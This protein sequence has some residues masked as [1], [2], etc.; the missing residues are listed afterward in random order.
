MSTSN[1]IWRLIVEQTAE[2]GQIIDGKAY[3]DKLVSL[4]KEYPNAISNRITTSVP[5]DEDAPQWEEILSNFEKEYKFC[6]REC[7]EL[8]ITKFIHR[9]HMNRKFSD[10]A[11]EVSFYQEELLVQFYPIVLD[12]MKHPHFERPYQIGGQLPSDTSVHLQFFK[13]IE[14]EDRYY[15]YLKTFGFKT[16]FTWLKGIDLSKTSRKTNSLIDKESY[17]RIYR[18]LREDYGRQLVEGWTENSNP[19]KT[20]FEDCGIAAYI[21]EIIN[22]GL[23][24]KPNKFVDIGCG[25]GLLVH[26]LNLTGLSGYGIDVRS[27][28]LWKT[29]LKHVDLRESTVEPQVI[30]DNEPHFD[31]GV[32]LLIGNHSD[33]LTPWIPVM[34]AKLNC[35]FFLIPCCP[36]DFFGKYKNNGSHLGQKRMVSQYES[37]FEWTV[38]VAERLGFDCQLDRLAIP[39]TKRLC[40]IGRIPPHGL[41]PNIAE[42][43]ELMTQGQKFVAR[44]RAIKNNNCMNIPVSE[45]DRMAKKLFDYVLKASDEVRDGWHCGGEVPL[46]ELAAILTDED[47]KMMKDQDGGLQTFLRNHHQIFHVYQATC[48]LRDFRQPQVKRDRPA[49]SKKR[50][51]D[52]EKETP[53]KKM[54][55]FMALYHPDGCAVGPEAC[56]Y[57][58]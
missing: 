29:T 9:D 5:I 23:I 24:P 55:C 40:I 2:Y 49:W 42:T 34:A 52:G 11:Y 3:F 16:V 44:P 38:T 54:P 14:E 31:Q 6:P 50:N 19:Q 4:W 1:T 47:K 56:R 30:V 36:F 33:E 35:N 13:P 57:E 48:R 37:F 53:R 28:K 12:H 18:Q 51:S 15:E 32:D 58:H 17:N 20:V 27:R 7:S 21:N 41:C 43:I 26:L 22:G 8:S 45:R 39:S 46:A 10:N 25:N